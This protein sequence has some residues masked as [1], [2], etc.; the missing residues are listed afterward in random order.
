MRT[1]FATA[2]WRNSIL[3]PFESNHWQRFFARSWPVIILLSTAFATGLSA[4]GIS[5][6]GTRSE[7]KS[8]N[9]RFAIRNFDS[10]MANPAHTLTLIATQGSLD[11][12]I[13]R[14]GRSVDI[15][16]S[17]NSQAFVVNDHEG[18]NVSHPVLFTEPWSAN[19]TDLREKLIGFLRPKNEAQ[20]LLGNHHVYV[21]AQRWLSNKEILCKAS[22]YGD[23]DPKG[24]TRYYRYEIGV[25]FRSGAM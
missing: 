11:I 12:T 18:S 7:S 21:T 20:S 2:I 17:P 4:Q 9:G 13:Y 15:L 5:F 16:W 14:Y 6:P 23:V 10:D 25:G 3:I 8:P 19:N 24:F 22:G 1:G